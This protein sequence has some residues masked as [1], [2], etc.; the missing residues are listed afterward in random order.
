MDFS[1][2]IY[3]FNNQRSQAKPLE[4][5]PN[6]EHLKST[7][8]KNVA[9]LPKFSNDRVY[10][11]F[12]DG[13][14]EVRHSQSFELIR[15][16]N[17][18]EGFDC[19]FD[20]FDFTIS[21]NMLLLVVDLTLRAY[22]IENFE[23]LSECEIGE[24]V[25]MNRTVIK[26]NFFYYEDEDFNRKLL[27]LESFGYE[28][29]KESDFFSSSVLLDKDELVLISGKYSDRIEFVDFKTG[30][31]IHTVKLKEILAEDE[32]SSICNSPLISDNVLVIPIETNYILALDIATK[33]PLWSKKV[34]ADYPSSFAVLNGKL[35]FFDNRAF[36]IYDLYSGELIF[37]NQLYDA[38][39]SNGFDKEKSRLVFDKQH[40]YCVSYENGLLGIFQMSNGDLKVKYELDDIVT[41]ETFPLITEH[42]IFVRDISNHLHVFHQSNP[43]ILQ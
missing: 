35:Y 6:V 39:R 2:N 20:F 37:E 42:Q 21:N 10:I 25:N 3:L 12:N 24:I 43:F 29:E 5:Y 22:D 19:S 8:L 1:Y 14:L 36:F 11:L 17:L 7:V 34:M 23:L 18:V 40:I 41:S 32:P 13:G 9:R 28:W 16:E 38:W 26:D 27:S 31:I 4:F 33:K 30:E 15:K